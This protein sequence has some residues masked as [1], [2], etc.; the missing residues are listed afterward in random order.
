MKFRN[1]L[2]AGLAV[3]SL[4]A[5]SNDDEKGIEGA[6]L[7]ASLSIDV[8]SVINTKAGYSDTQTEAEATM[9]NTI[10]TVTGAGFSKVYDAAEYVKTGTINIVKGDGLI[11]GGVYTIKA[12]VKGSQAATYPAVAL[13]AETEANGFTMYGTTT[14]AALGASDNTATVTVDRTVARVDFESLEL[15]Y[16]GPAQGAT[17]VTKFIVESVKLT[18]VVNAANATSGLGTAGNEELAGS[19]AGDVNY[20]NT[21]SELGQFYVYPNAAKTTYLVISGKLVYND[22]TE[23]PT[24]YSTAIDGTTVSGQ[25]APIARNTI[26]NIAAKITG[27]G[28][29]IEGTDLA[30]T[31][32]CADWKTVTLTPDLD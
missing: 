9:K 32:T 17:K 30:L 22:G 28:S 5:C 1:L 21:V 24:S 10:I 23:L 8:A 20:N 31:I 19:Y 29:D 4:A 27:D 12:D 3:C 11:V 18:G 6:G 13:D 25:T 26:Y 16:E 15:A 2:F 14:T 7:P